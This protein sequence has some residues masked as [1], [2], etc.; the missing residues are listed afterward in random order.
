M[1]RESG[2]R[3]TLGRACEDGDRAAALEPGEAREARTG[4]RWVGVFP[5]ALEGCSSAD[6]LISAF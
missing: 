3:Q 1:E 2:Q 6:N 4:R 5:G